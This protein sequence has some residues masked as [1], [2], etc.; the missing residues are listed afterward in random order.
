MDEFA[1]EIG[2]PSKLMIDPADEHGGNKV[3]QVA[4]ECSMVL[5]IFEE[6]TQWAKLVQ[7]YVAILKASVLKD[8]HDSFV[9]L[10]YSVE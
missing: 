10:C 4:K 7:K 1:R 6:S 2:V 5:K 8:F 3:R 9:Q